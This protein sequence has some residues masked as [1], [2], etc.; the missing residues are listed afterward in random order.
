LAYTLAAMIR[1]LLVG[2][3]IFLVSLMFTTMPIVHPTAAV[4]ML[5]L[6]SFM[7]SQFGLLAALVAT[8]FD[9][10]SM[11]TNFLL[12]PLIYLGGLFYP[13]TILPKPWSLVSQANPLFYLISGFRGAVL[14]VGDVSMTR[15]F[16]VAIALSVGLFAW[17][18]YL[19]GSGRKLRS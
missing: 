18:A 1:G 10:L 12:L 3:V 13:V 14:G 15:A 7:F 8:N 9:T 5:A 4:A 2:S 16:A 6:S 17:A 19:I 11:F